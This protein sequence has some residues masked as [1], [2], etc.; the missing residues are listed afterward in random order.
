MK[1]K[2]KLNLRDRLTTKDVAIVKLTVWSAL[3]IWMTFLIVFAIVGAIVL[4]DR[5]KDVWD[6]VAGDIMSWF[7]PIW[8]IYTILFVVLLVIR[9]S[10]KKLSRKDTTDETS[11]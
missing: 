3:I 6:G 2:M 4:A 8:F 11:P 7:L 5:S 10:G 1:L 9:W